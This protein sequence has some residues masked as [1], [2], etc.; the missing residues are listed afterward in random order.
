MANATMPKNIRQKWMFAIEI[1]GFNA[2]LFTKC[3]M[4]KA[5]FEE[6]TFSPAGSMFDQ[7]VPGRVKFEDIT[8]E[9]GILVD[10]ADDSA[11]SWLKSQADLE[12]GTGDNPEAFMRDVDIIERNRQGEET[13]RFTLHGAW[14]KKYEQDDNDG[15]SSDAAI[16]KI[17]LCYQ[18]WTKA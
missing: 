18:Y 14:I 2:A 13:R 9:K 3:Q 6:A 7:K 12:A 1:N 15:G 17:T 16:E 4:P 5:E 8:L 10:G 11:L